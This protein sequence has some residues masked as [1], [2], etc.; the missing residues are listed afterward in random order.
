M[1]LITDDYRAQQRTMHET[2]TYGIAS[3]H[4][5]K[6]I[7][8]VMNQYHVSELL[9]YGAGSRLTLYKTLGEQ[10]LVEHAFKYTPY[11]PA[12]EQY[13]DTPEPTE[14]VACLDVLEHV[15]PELI[16]NVLDDLA[17]V[18]KRCGVFSVSCVPALKTLPDGRNAHLIQQP[19]EWWLP[20]LMERFELQSY[21]MSE[22]GFVVLVTTKDIQ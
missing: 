17:R 8:R 3:Q 11:E 9:D 12:V 13:A 22:D 19:P 5:A 14:M 2:T 4:F 15:E 1:M 10:R 21:Q 18:T 16:D 7:A 20:K 6:L